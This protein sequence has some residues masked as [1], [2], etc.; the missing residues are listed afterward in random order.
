MNKARWWLRKL[1]IPLS[2]VVLGLV[3]IFYGLHVLEQAG[4]SANWPA[5]S[6]KVLASGIE[7]TLWSESKRIND[8]NT[9]TRT[10]KRYGPQVRYEYRAYGM[11]Y[12]G[13]GIRIVDALHE[14]PEAVQPIVARYPVDSRV[15]V[16]FNPNDPAQAVLEPGVDEDSYLFLYGGIAWSGVWGGVLA[17]AALVVYFREAGARRP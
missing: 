17:V 12:T 5:V 13:Q 8:R 2:M 1:T 9:G 16:Y 3:I 6:G 15:R 11:L 7:E 14:H 4:A 10:E